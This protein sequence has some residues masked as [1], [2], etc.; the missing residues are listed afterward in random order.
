MSED[1][2]LIVQ[3]EYP[4]K[5]SSAPSPKDET[6]PSPSV[7]TPTSV[8]ADDKTP[9]VSAQSVLAF[10]RSPIGALESKVMGAVP[11]A[12]AAVAIYETAKQI[13]TK[14]ISLRSEMTGDATLQMATETLGKD[15]GIIMNPISS[16][17]SLAEQQAS[18]DRQNKRI[19]QQRALLGEADVNGSARRGA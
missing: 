12:A 7:Q 14:V 1:Y 4:D 11:Y 18:I 16:A 5:A 10:A 9:T 2:R 17:F 8:E 15:V 6:S 19:E 13:G 3:I